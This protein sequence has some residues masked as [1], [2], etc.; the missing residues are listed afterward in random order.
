MS[1]K[2]GSGAVADVKL[3]STQVSKIYLGSTEVF[4]YA[5]Y[6]PDA[7]AWFDAIVAAGSTISDNNKAAVSAFVAGCKADGVWTPIKSCCLLCAADSLPGAL[8]PLVGTAPTNVNFAPTDYSRTIGLLG[9]GVTKYLVSNRAQNADPQ[10]SKHLAA[11]VS[12]LGNQSGYMLGTV[13]LCHLFCLGGTTIFFRMNPSSGGYSD[14]LTAGF[15]GGSRGAADNFQWRHSN[16]SGTVL[17]NSGSTTSTIIHAFRSNL[18]SNYLNCRLA[19]YSIG[20]A[21]DLVSL[22]ARLS[23]LMSSLT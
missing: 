11:W 3:G 4:S 22:N 16:K 14:T 18:N 13:D 17:Q 19:F 1:L 6:D 5:A 23:T 2:I 8:V 12:S 20:E 10:N 15:C 9:D 21:I 7:Q